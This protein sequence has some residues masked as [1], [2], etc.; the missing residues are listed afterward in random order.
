[1]LRAIMLPLLLGNACT[2]WGDEITFWDAAHRQRTIEVN[3]L[4]EN[5]QGDL[6]AESPDGREWLINR[7]QIVSH[8]R[9]EEKLAPLSRD[10]LV[11]ALTKEFPPSF[12]QLETKHYV[13]IYSTDELFAKE[14]AKLLERIKTV[15]ENYLRKQ[16]SF[17]SASRDKQAESK[18]PM[19]AV[20]F[21]TQKEYVDYLQPRLGPSVSQTAGVYLPQDHRLYLFNMLG[22]RGADWLAQASKA[23][24]KSPDQISLLLATDT[25][26]TVIHEGV[27]QVAFN[28]GFHRR[29]VSQPIWLLEGWATLLEVP[30][31]EGKTRW[32]G[33]GQINGDRADEL[34]KGWGKVSPES[35]ES[36]IAGD[37]AFRSADTSSLA[38]AQA[39]G[40]TYYLIKMKKQAFGMY[41]ERINARPEWVPYLAEDRL[42]DFETSF[43]ISPIRMEAEFKRWIEKNVFKKDRPNE[44]GATP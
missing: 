8:H 13:L 19:V 12:R 3:L 17:D 38:Y 31:L 20:I 42:R 6:F 22:G 37:D 5:E 33:L 44:P 41:V 40:L 7:S 14:A 32:A 9:H 10:E 11:S 2:A 23:V 43:G 24:E 4:H 16:L 30:D 25:V 26:S 18:L 27:H 39:W 1:M 28:I 36:L 15:S 21:G 29:R 34:R 35:I